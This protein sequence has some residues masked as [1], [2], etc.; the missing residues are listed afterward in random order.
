[1]IRR[2]PWGKL[3]VAGFCLV[4]VGCEPHHSWLRDKG[5]DDAKALASGSPTQD[6]LKSEKIIGGS[7]EDSDARSIFKGTR[8]SGGWSS[9]AREIEKDL[10][11]N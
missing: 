5:D 11:V 8:R 3:F 6:D 9:E 7:A 1:M 4:P 2:F 10:Y